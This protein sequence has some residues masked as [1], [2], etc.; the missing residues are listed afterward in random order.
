VLNTREQMY[1]VS[2]HRVHRP[3]FRTVIIYNAFPFGESRQPARKI[4]DN[5]TMGF[6]RHRSNNHD[7]VAP[8]KTSWSSP[9]TIFIF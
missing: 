4:N 5:T 2:I 9:K 8:P 3:D 1:A 7:C 6:R